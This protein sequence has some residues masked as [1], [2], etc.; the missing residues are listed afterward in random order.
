MADQATRPQSPVKAAAGTSRFHQGA[1]LRPCRRSSSG[2]PG[3]GAFWVWR[4][5]ERDKQRNPL[6]ARCE[7]LIAN[8]AA[9]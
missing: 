3:V 5:Q 9:A 6:N 4:A 1:N 8:V 2:I 7:T